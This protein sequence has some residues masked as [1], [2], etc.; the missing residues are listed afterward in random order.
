MEG[1][2]NGRKLP[3][4]YSDV[5]GQRTLHFLVLLEKVLLPNEPHPITLL[6]DGGEEAGA[7]AAALD[8]AC[9]SQSL[10]EHGCT[11]CWKQERPGE[12][13]CAFVRGR[14]EGAGGKPNGIERKL[15]ASAK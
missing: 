12:G 1:G 5:V 15:V 8:K 13:G 4:P 9:W 2:E 14:R 11:R 6:G 3:L 7:T 10:L